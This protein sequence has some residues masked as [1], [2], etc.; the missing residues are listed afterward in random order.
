M[1]DSTV[2]VLNRLWQPVDLTRARRAFCLLY[3]GRA[4]VVGEDYLTYDWSS[5]VDLSQRQQAP[6]EEVVH[7]VSFQVRVPRVVQLLRYDG[8]PQ[9]GIK[10]TRTNVYLRDRHR[11]QYCGRKGS[12][13][14]LNI[15]HLVPRSRGGVSTWENVV[16]A[17]VPCNVRKGDNLP[18]EVGMRPLRPPQRPRWHPTLNLGL[19]AELHPQWR[20]FLDFARLSAEPES[21]LQP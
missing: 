9:A 20:P 18:E 7:G 2:L 10:F 17:C 12:A 11:C 21:A 3:G 6:E 1:L 13:A 15:D 16:V 8:M 5:W 4:K 14:E 19:E